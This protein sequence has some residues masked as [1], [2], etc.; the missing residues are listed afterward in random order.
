M[1]LRTKLGFCALGT[2]LVFVLLRKTP[3]PS[4][5]QTDRQRPDE[6]IASF[7]ITFLTLLCDLATK[8]S[9]EI[10]ISLVPRSDMKNHKPFKIFPF[11]PRLL[12]A[13]S[14]YLSILEKK[15]KNRHT[16]PKHSCLYSSSSSFFRFVPA[17]PHAVTNWN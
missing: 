11:L 16:S 1:L 12:A 6:R 15:Q 3:S 9:H 7:V 2:K 13:S 5:R 17:L 14:D 4:D 10:S 8:K